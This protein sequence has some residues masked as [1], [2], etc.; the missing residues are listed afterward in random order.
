M[1]PFSGKPQPHKKRRYGWSPDLKDPRDLKFSQKVAAPIQE[2]LPRSVDLRPQCSPV[3]DQGNLGSCTANAL[4]GALEFLELMA[5]TPLVTKSRL[6][7]YYNERQADGTVASDAGSQ[8]RTGI[9]VVAKQGAC[10]ETLWPYDPTKFTNKPPAVAYVQA[11]NNLITRYWRLDTLQDMKACLSQGY[12]FVF[13]FTVFEGFESLDV[14]K[15]GEV[16]MP[17]PGESPLGGHAVMACGYDDSKGVLIVRN[18]WGPG[19][20][21]TGYFTLPYGY[22][23]QGLATDFWSISKEMI[24]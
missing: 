10:A 1:W 4:A 22:I 2:L 3:V 11:V 23:E 8:L 15:T 18:S 7:I 19:W 14:A 16:P 9:K 17:A 12:P 5:R 24:N 20:G 21:Q 13:G 6:F